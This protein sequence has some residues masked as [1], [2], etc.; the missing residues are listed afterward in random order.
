MHLIE[1]YTF[2][3]QLV[4]HCTVQNIF[5]P[6][7]FFADLFAV[8]F[9]NQ[10]EEDSFR[11]ERTEGIIEAISIIAIK[12]CIKSMN[13]IGFFVLGD[14]RM[15]IRILKLKLKYFTFKKHIKVFI[16][17]IILTEI[18]KSPCPP[19]ITWY[20]ISMIWFFCAFS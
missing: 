7:I 18:S 19:S 5:A 6:F 13:I 2:P 3:E 8:P 20:S 11:I 9:N 4:R 17:K 14:N 12:C 10:F 15:S 16:S 1:T